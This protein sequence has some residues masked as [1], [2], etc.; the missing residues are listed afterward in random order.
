MFES[1]NRKI[2]STKKQ[3]TNN[4]QIRNSKNPPNPPCKKEGKRLGFELLYFKIY[5][6]FGI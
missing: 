4:I 1:L 3:I 6:R 2:P 5:L